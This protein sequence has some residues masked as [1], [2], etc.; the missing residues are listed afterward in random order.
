MVLQVSQ[1]KAQTHVENF[2]YVSVAPNPVGVGQP[3]YISMFFTKPLPP[4]GGMFGEGFYH[5][6]TL[7]I[8]LPNGSTETSDY[9]IT[10]STGGIG[11]IEFTPETTGE[12]KVKASYAGENFGEWILDPDE[13]P[14][15]TFV[16]QEEQIPGFSSNPLPTEYWW[17]RCLWKQLQSI[18]PSTKQRSHHVC[19][20]NIAWR[21]SRTT[22][23]L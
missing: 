1:I 22:H 18:Q 4:E 8:T 16:V 12:Y 17:I 7:T 6:L 21:S 23:K 19:Y 5:D 20:A 9:E 11:G 3:V 15:V 14:E 2:L 13:S 10:D